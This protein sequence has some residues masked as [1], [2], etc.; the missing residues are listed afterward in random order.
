[1][2]WFVDAA[3]G[4]RPE[5]PAS[6]VELSIVTMGMAA[7]LSPNVERRFGAA[8]RVSIFIDD[9]IIPFN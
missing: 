6:V 4:N 5:R 7:Q 8:E 9:L 1:M 2:Q 3:G